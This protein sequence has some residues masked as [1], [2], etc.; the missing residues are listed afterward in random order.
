M[1]KRLH[2]SWIS[3]LTYRVEFDIGLEFLFSLPSHCV[4][5]F[6]LDTVKR[7]MWKTKEDIEVTIS[8][9]LLGASLF[10]ARVDSRAPTVIHLILQS[11]V[12]VV[13]LDMEESEWL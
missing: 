8:L 12:P 9:S 5:R 1:L 3:L 2:E 7:S 13:K 10:L 6:Q 11:E 4:R